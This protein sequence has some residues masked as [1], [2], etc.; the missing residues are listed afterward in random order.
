MIYLDALKAY[1]KK[2]TAELKSIIKKYLANKNLNEQ[3][4]LMRWDFSDVHGFL[5]TEPPSSTLFLFQGLI[6][7]MEGRISGEALN[8]ILDDTRK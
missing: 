3:K 1:I 6:N 8:K 4:R 5:A 2:D 7:H